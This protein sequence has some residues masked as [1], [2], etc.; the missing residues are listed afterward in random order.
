MWHHE[1]I[2]LCTVNGLDSSF[3]HLME[4]WTYG[5]MTALLVP[6]TQSGQHFSATS[7]SPEILIKSVASNIGT[8]RLVE[9]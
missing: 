8:K 2:A 6:Q 1:K 9:A 5:T 3:L 4:L 7:D